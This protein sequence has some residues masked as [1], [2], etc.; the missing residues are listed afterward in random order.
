MFV[1]LNKRLCLLQC[2]SAQT[3][4]LGQCD[5][6]LKPEFCFSFRMIDVHMQARFFAGEEKEPE[7][8]RAKNGWSHVV[9][10]APGNARVS[11]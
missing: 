7:T 8:M 2:F 5:L 3:D 6:R 1:L 9:M 4:V 11:E 10:V